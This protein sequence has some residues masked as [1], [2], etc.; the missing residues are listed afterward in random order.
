MTSHPLTPLSEYQRSSQPATDT[1]HYK[2]YLE[3]ICNNATLALFVMDEHQQCVYMNPAAEQLTGFTLAE[4]EGRALHDVIHHTRPDGT[5]Y[6]L[7]ECPIDQVFP[8]NNQ[9]QG[10]E[11]FVH[12]NGHFYPVTYT[13]SPIRQSGKTIGTVIEVRDITQEELAAQAQQEAT[14][15]ERVLRQA[16]ESAKERAETVLQ[17]ITEAFVVFDREWHYLYVSPSATRLLQKSEAE[18]IGRRV[19]DVFPDLVATPVY[20]AYHRSVAEQIPIEFEF[21]YPTWDRWFVNRAYPSDKGLSVFVTDIT[22]RKHTEQAL[23]ESEARFRRLFEGNMVP[24]AIWTIE[25]RVTEANNALLDLIG[26]SRSELEAGQISWRALTPP[27]WEAQDAKA[28][29][30]VVTQGYSTP[31]E[32][33]YWHKDGRRIPILISAGLFEDGSQSGYYFAIDLTQLKQTQASLKEADSL[34]S[35]AL[36]AGSI[37]TW[38]WDLRQNLIF[39]DLEFAN[40][41]GVLPENASQGLPIEFFLAGMHPDDRESVSAAIRKA[42]DTGEEYFAEYRLQSVKGERWVLARGRVEYDANEIPIS[43]PGAVCDITERKQI[44]AALRETEERLRSA[45]ECAKLGT[46]DFNL[47]T[48]Q[49]TWDNGCKTMFGLSIDA[50]VNYAQFE[51]LLHPEDLA[52]TN[53]RVEAAIA[54]GSSGEFK[55]EY[56]VIRASDGAERWIS[57]T[58]QALFDPSGKAVRLIGAVIDITETKQQEAERQ[59]L[60]E[61]EQRLREQAEQANRIKDEFLAV[62]SHEL[63]TPLNPILGWVR[64]LRAGKC[65]PAKVPQALETIERNAQLQAQLIEDLLDVSRI[66]QG[67]LTLNSDS[68]N[69]VETIRAA[70]ETVQLAAESKAIEVHLHLD[71][72]VETVRGDANRLQQVLWNLL[73]NAVKF[74]DHAGRVD[75][76]LSQVGTEAE[77]QIRDTGKGIRSEVLPYI[78]DRFRQGDSSTTR[79]F[80]GLGLGLAIARHLVELHGGTISAE[81]AGENQGAT[82]TVRLPLSLFQMQSDAPEMPKSSR[83]LAGIKILAV[84]DEPD[85]LDFLVFLLEAM[86]AIVESARSAKSA[87]EKLSEFQPDLLISDIAMPDLDGYQ[88]IQQIREQINVPAIALTA[89]AG[90]T[91]QRQILAAGFQQHLAKPVDPD[92]LVNTIVALL[93]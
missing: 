59:Q 67:K 1:Q 58:G 43:F 57:A 17:S 52:L 7:C 11:V 39:I 93:N 37:Y 73:S 18:L 41:F 87:F 13:A 3:A 35:S 54:P 60:L 22:D 53:Q 82:F 49:L 74:T 26:Y 25:G 42:I 92:E 72:D 2:Q 91:N 70:L 63:R 45:I 28:V 34:L 77:I 44:E 21:L 6:P 19:W 50:E 90:E 8:K 23:R 64:M 65:P 33:E 56:R 80:G 66:L 15:R 10:E 79:Q 47:L 86:G 68:V 38:R 24:L 71:S 12:R 40:L 62:L 4:V 88:L 32:K 30:E 9:E 89:Y 36:A 5:P 29:E 84:D 78:F 69:L 75:V 20:E 55:A 76:K 16:A 83:D 27:E 81:S 85:N 46:W 31:Y 48:E 14:E 61:R 51:S